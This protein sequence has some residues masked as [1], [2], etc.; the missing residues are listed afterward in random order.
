[1]ERVQADERKSWDE[2][3]FISSHS[4]PTPTLQLTGAR[5][6][7]ARADNAVKLMWRGGQT[8]VNV[9]HKRW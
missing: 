7:A 9:R 5:G 3:P 4:H 6:Q 2:S 8:K 1:M